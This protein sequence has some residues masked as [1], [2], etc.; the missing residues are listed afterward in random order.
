MEPRS[1][2]IQVFVGNI[3]LRHFV[4]VNFP[5]V[6][7][8]GV[9]DASDCVCFEGVPFV[10]QLVDAFRICTLDVRQSLQVARLSSRRRGR[11]FKSWQERVDSLVFCTDRPRGC[12]V[13]PRS[14]CFSDNL[15]AGSSLL[16]SLL[17]LHRALGSSPLRRWLLDAGELLFHGG[18]F[19]S[20]LFGGHTPQSTT[21]AGCKS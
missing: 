15:P 12:T 18:L 4:G 1:I 5:F 7:V 9:F 8:I 19:L 17:F 2:L 14:G 20:F 21:A 6:G 16:L 10:K 13:G 3:V 11:T